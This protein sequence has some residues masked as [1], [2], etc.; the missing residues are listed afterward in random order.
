MSS[1]DDER[2][3]SIVILVVQR[4]LGYD[5]NWI[6]PEILPVLGPRY[7]SSC[8]QLIIEYDE[9]ISGMMRELSTKSLQEIEVDFNADGVSISDQG[10][11]WRDKKKQELY[12]KY[13]GI[14][15]IYSAALGKSGLMADPDNWS[16]MAFL[17]PNEVLWLSVGLEPMPFAKVLADK[18]ETEESESETIILLRKRKEQVKRALH[19][20]STGAS[21]YPGTILDWVVRVGLEIHPNF[22]LILERMIQAISKPLGAVVPERIFEGPPLMEKPDRREIHSLSTLILAMAIDHYGFDPDAGRSVV[23]KEIVNMMASLGLEMTQETV[24]K[25]LRM[26]RR[27]LPKGWKPVP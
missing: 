17:N 16:K 5:Y 14:P 8:E 18:P 19:P 25:Y 13:R 4:V 9:L 21:L 11:M 12:T 10:R 26:G 22:Q 2:K 15:K 27:D 6:K 1:D 23:P 20:H 7:Y 24:L 3:K